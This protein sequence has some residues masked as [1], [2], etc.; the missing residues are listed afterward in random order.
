MQQQERLG[1]LLPDR[2]LLGPTLLLAQRS[3]RGLHDSNNTPWCQLSPPST[4]H[5]PMKPVWPNVT[6][7]VTGVSPTVVHEL[8]NDPYTIP[9]SHFGLP[10]FWLVASDLWNTFLSFP[11]RNSLPGLQSLS[12]LHDFQEAILENQCYHEIATFSAS[13]T[14]DPVAI[15]GLGREQRRG[16]PVSRYPGVLGIPHWHMG[17]PCGCFPGPHGAGNK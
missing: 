10:G 8:V 11:F 4:D 5:R 3:S 2:D 6:A 7:E 12:Q 1:K 15:G 14:R 17:Q 13:T 16:A 9:S